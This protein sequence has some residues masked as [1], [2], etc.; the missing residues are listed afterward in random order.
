MLQVLLEE[1]EALVVVVAVAVAIVAVA[2]GTF[3]RG[4]GKKET[5][6]EDGFV[7][8]IPILYPHKFAN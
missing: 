4:K 7:M 2:R 8:T 5:K 1:G 6:E 3:Q